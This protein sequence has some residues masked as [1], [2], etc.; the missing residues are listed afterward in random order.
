MRPTRA[1]SER[2]VGP[3]GLSIAALAFAAAF[4]ALGPAGDSLPGL[5]SD[6][7]TSASPDP[8]DGAAPDALQLAYL[9]A[10][11]ANGRLDAAQA[12]AAISALARAGRLEQTRQLLAE[13]P[14]LVFAA[15]ERFAIDLDLAAAA[16][17]RAANPAEAASSRTALQGLLSLVAERDTLQR[18]A[19]LKRATALADA[20]AAAPTR[21][22]LY[23]VRAKVEPARAASW[24][25]ACGRVLADA[26]HH[27]Q[28]STCFDAASRAATDD[29]QRFSID[30]ERLALSDDDVPGRALQRSL[31]ERD[32]VS[33]AFREALASVLLASEQPGA[34]SRIFGE[35]AERDATRRHQWLT[36]AARWAEAAARPA[37]AAAWLERL[38][39]ADD[40][41]EDALERVARRERI[42]QLL[43]AA[44]DSEA[45]LQRVAA[46]HARS[47]SDPALTDA[48]VAMAQ[49]AG[50]VAQALSINTR[51]LSS[52]ADDLPALD[53]QVEL[54]L[55]LGNPML[56]RR[57]AETA[58]TR[59]PDEP[60]RREH[61]AQLAEWSGDPE[62]ALRERQRAADDGG[63][64]GNL[65]ELARLA[66]AVRRPE[67]AADARLTLARRDPPDARALDR[68]VEQFE[69]AGRPDAAVDAIESL[70]QLHGESGERLRALARLHERHEQRRAAL[71]AWERHAAL[72]G[73]TDENALARIELAWR[74]G[75]P[76]AALQHARA[77]AS[78]SFGGQA[79]DYQ[80]SV[81]AEL[82]WRYRDAEVSAL[83]QPL[84]ATLSDEEQRQRQTRRAIEALSLAGRKDE[85]A[86]AAEAEWRANGD[87]ELAL[88]AL[89]LT[90][91][92][93]DMPALERLLGAT[94]QQQALLETPAWWSIRAAHAL[95]DGDT[96]A[97]QAH[98]ERALAI[99]PQDTE[100]NAG[101]LWLA[102]GNNDTALLSRLI[103]ERLP[104]LQR[105]PTLWP[106][107]AMAHV[108]LG[109]AAASLPWFERAVQSLGSDYAL[110]LG[111]A[112]A[113]EQAGEVDRALSVR[114]WAL[115][116]LRP[117]LV[118]GVAGQEEVLLQQYGRLLSRYG[119]A[120]DNEAW[121]RFVLSTDLD[122]DDRA[123]IWREDIAIAWLM[124][125][126]RHEHARLIMT[127]RH[128]RRLTNP[129]WQDL[130]LALRADD[131]AAIDAMLASGAGLS[132]GGRMLA[133]R[134][135]G[136]D[137]EAFAL[138]L[139]TLDAPASEEDLAIAQ[140]QYVQLRRFRP[141][142][143]T[144]RHAATQRGALSIAR[145]GVAIRH[146]PGVD[147]FGLALD[148]SH[149]RYDS[150]QLVTGAAEERP[151]AEL[152][153]FRRDS[154]HAMAMRIGVDGE[155]DDELVYAGADWAL[156]D[157][158]GRRELSLSVG[159]GEPAD[160]SAELTL[161][162]RRDR[163][164]LGLE[165]AIGDSAFARLGVRA[166]E[167]S[168]RI[169]E[170]RLAR[171]IRTQAEVGLRGHRGST[172]WTTSIT[173]ENAAYQRVE[174][175]P[176]EFVLSSGT[177]LDTVLSG[178]RTA[179]TLG[180]SLSRGGIESDFPD[181][182]SPRYYLIGGIGHVWPERSIGWQVDAGAGLRV[183]GN[184][185]LGLSISHDASLRATD[186][187]S[188]ATS[189]GVRYRRHF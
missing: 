176:A 132:V 126:E 79:S 50:E 186:T 160:E 109:D 121:M 148:L 137:A 167:L 59:A 64:A 187:D 181:V 8:G 26:G 43:L 138:A 118:A 133:L 177:T 163:I 111:W 62:A 37:E 149:A 182:A 45:A 189:L 35:L 17:R 57:W 139:R 21:A 1:R 174:R 129:V 112:D 94:A 60:Q 13:M 142:H 86:T 124:A 127:R 128:D 113:L 74:L 42:E 70:M 5:R 15:D 169:D 85:A 55:A 83:A 72:V 141:S 76:V 61:L 36:Q 58:M 136:R 120:D 68:L 115:G 78:R 20:F 34:A 48:A 24:L 130:A 95:R 11:A 103:A 23:R 49:A 44:G 98:Y 108:A 180:A 10:A 93:D 155:A 117:R 116:E 19:V 89:R 171:G 92:A 172:A 151:R 2:L 6:A 170:Q 185:E 12:R 122:G 161:A 147:G 63:T 143:I 80:A 131:T 123:R 47:P 100:A 173:A 158:R 168:G 125:T 75:E 30:L 3:F 16:V 188:D 32:R 39:T 87:S 22:D 145:T 99:A 166:S 106:A 101:L 157:R 114:A 4:V 96:P 56:A 162:G 31:I 119:T 69:T 159:Y 18:P 135:V 77:L 52:G 51:Y 27:R 152:E 84:I 65:R 46:R 90:L 140:Q 82:G 97:A 179:L 33:P 150:Q 146:A 7:T 105:V 29:E 40:A 110:V 66:E 153:L 54:A 41:P 25:S 102:I 184:D 91:D 165:S 38:D 178:E 71:R 154:R 53:R 156:R 73:P 144:A 164:D 9:K 104:D 183:L 175:L 107:I 67:V 14:D 81:L 28:A 88:Q 134:K